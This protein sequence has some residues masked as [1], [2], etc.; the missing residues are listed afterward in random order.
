MAQNYLF[1]EYLFIEI[2]FYR[3]IVCKNIVC[4]VGL[5]ETKYSATIVLCFSPA[6]RSVFSFA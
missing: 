1:I 5:N 4:D 6:F 2:S 3:N